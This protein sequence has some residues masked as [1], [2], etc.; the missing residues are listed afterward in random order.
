MVLSPAVQGAGIVGPP[1]GRFNIAGL[2]TAITSLSLRGLLNFL[3][4]QSRVRM[5]SYAIKQFMNPALA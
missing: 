1:V 5:V 2:R 3:E 4:L